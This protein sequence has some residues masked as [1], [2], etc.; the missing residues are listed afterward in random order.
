MNKMFTGKTVIFLL[1]LGVPV[2]DFQLSSYIFYLVL[3][4]KFN[5]SV[6][7]KIGF[8]AKSIQFLHW[9]KLSKIIKL[10]VYLSR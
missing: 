6:N 2:L 8:S 9:T 7:T 1:C 3:T 5:S 4:N 10:I